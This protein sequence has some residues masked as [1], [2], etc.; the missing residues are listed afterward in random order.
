M[1]NPG[2]VIDIEIL[3]PG[4]DYQNLRKSFVIFI[5]NYDPFAMN[6]CI[7]TFENRCIEEPEVVF[8]DETLKVIVNTKGTVGEISEELRELLVYLDEG[9]AT[10]DYTRQLDNAV[11]SVKSSEARRHEY[12]VMMIREMELK[13]EARAEGRAEGRTEGRAEGVDQTRAESIKNIMK[14]L[15]YTAQ[16]AMDLLEIPVADQSRYFTKL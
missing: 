9:R 3:A 2:S 6:R 8:G 1:N 16:Q 13:E 10:G 14:K 11:R 12:M 5:C 7:Y 4:V 15:K